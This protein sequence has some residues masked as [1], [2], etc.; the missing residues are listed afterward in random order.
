M[1]N[2]VFIMA[3]IFCLGAYNQEEREINKI[4]VRVYDFEGLKIGK[5][6]IKVITANSLHLNRKGR[7]LEISFM[8]IGSIKTKRSAGNNILIGA[9]TG[10]A[11]LGILGA[12]TADSMNWST[13]EV[14]LAGAVFGGA[15]GVAI[16]GFSALFKNSESYKIEG[17]KA[18]WETFKE[19]ILYKN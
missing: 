12:T 16:G 18:K 7:L 19:S 2:I 15:V 5:G 4:F 11:T 14:A 13:D 17:D 9:A 8:D 3:L 1:K 6:K 10:A